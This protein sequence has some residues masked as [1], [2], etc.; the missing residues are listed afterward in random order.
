VLLRIGQRIEDE[1]F[2]EEEDAA[3]TGKKFA[4]F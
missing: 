3:T 1:D 2:G 4:K